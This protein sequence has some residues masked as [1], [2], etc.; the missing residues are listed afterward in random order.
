MVDEPK[1]VEE[2]DSME[3]LLFKP[4]PEFSKHAYI[5]SMA[6]YQKDV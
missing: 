2:L 6:E 5:K 4:S 3:N 1:M